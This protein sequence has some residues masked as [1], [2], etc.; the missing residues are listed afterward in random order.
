MVRA[1][2]IAHKS[3]LAIRAD[4]PGARPPL[5]QVD[6]LAMSEEMDAGARRQARDVPGECLSRQIN[7]VGPLTKADGPPGT[8]VHRDGTI[9]LSAADDIRRLLGVEMAPIKCGSPASNWHQGDID[10]RHLVDG[11]LRT[12]VSRIPAPTRALDEI[13]E[14]GS[15]MGTPRVSA[16]VVISG[17]DAYLQSS[18]LHKITRLDLPEL[19]A[20]G[21]DWPEQTARTPRGD[22]NRRSRDQ[23]E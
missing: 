1:A 4:P 16:A 3:G 14:R 5:L 19:Y 15:A 21:G 17:Q 20:A 6:R 7:Q 13:A 2:A 11:N 9:W 10:V 23:S 8:P 18:K 12:C 22:E